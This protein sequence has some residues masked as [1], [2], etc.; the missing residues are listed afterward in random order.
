MARTCQVIGCG[1]HHKAGGLCGLHRSRVLQHGGIERRKKPDWTP[2]DDAR[3]MAIE[4]TPATERSATA[5][6]S[7]LRIYAEESGRTV[8]AIYQRRCRLLKANRS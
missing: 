4:P 6:M 1:R 5:G 2:D 3:L 7:A 8:T